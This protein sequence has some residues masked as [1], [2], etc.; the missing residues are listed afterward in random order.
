MKLRWSLWY[1]ELECKMRVNRVLA[2]RALQ[3]R[4]VEPKLL[5]LRPR[6]AQLD[7]KG[8]HK[9]MLERGLEFW[10]DK[11]IFLWSRVLVV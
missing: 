2:W 7:G 5:C 8:G 11:F 9:M 6:G 1:S 3:Q 4:G 10:G